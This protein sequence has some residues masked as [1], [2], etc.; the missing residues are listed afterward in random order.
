M[1]FGRSGDKG[2]T[3]R[4]RKQ[5]HDHLEELEDLRDERLE[6]L[7]SLAYEMHRRGR[8]VTNL[9]SER[10]AEIASIQAEADLVHRGLAEHL[11]LD[12][13]AEISKQAA[14]D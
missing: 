11:T 12:E 5:L 14:A 13:L 3:K 7:G 1:A 6:D 9:L 10:A 4:E 2:Q 8:F